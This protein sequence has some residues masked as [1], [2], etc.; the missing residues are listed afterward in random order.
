MLAALEPVRAGAEV[1]SRVPWGDRRSL[2]MADK[3]VREYHETVAKAEEEYFALRAAQ[4][5]LQ[6][7]TGKPSVDAS[8]TF[9]ELRNMPAIWKQRDSGV[10]SIR[11]RAPWP[12][13][14]AR[15][16]WLVTSDA[17]PWM[18]T[19]EECEDAYRD[20]VANNPM[21]GGIVTGDRGFVAVTSGRGLDRFRS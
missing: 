9:G 19:A 21:R 17:E 11:G 6:R 10:E 13:R 4:G 20:L 7:L 15:M 18:P 2:V 8:H 12:D 3:K 1:A 14:L 5:L 16:V